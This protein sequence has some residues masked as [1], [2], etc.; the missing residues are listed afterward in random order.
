MSVVLGNVMIDSTISGEEVERG[1]IGSRPVGNFVRHSIAS[2]DYRLPFYQ[3]LSFDLFVEATSKRVA[4]AL[5]TY[6][7]PARAVAH[8]GGRYRF[9]VADKPVLLRW[10]VQNVTN[11]FGWNNGNSGYFTPN[12]SRRWLLSLA[13]DV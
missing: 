7:I 6:Y 8:I 13:A 4:D 12:G 9:N 1:V 3:P 5:N 10:Q 11:K 2:V